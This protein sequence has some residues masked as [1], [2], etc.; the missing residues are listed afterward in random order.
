MS[1]YNNKANKDTLKHKI[2]FL[3]FNSDINLKGFD[4]I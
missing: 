3:Q 2:V 1:V 4:H